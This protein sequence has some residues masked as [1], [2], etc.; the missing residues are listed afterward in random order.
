MSDLKKRARDLADWHAGSGNELTAELLR[1]MATYIERLEA[2]ETQE[3]KWNALRGLH[4]ELGVKVG[5]CSA[6][7]AKVRWL[8]DI[9]RAVMMAPNPR[10]WNAITW[11]WMGKRLDEIRRKLRGKDARDLSGLAILCR[12]MAAA[13]DDEHTEENDDE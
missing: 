7:T 13:L 5:D 1:Q 9:Q 4:Q 11:S 3:G 8:Q 2:A 10:S 6:A 12:D